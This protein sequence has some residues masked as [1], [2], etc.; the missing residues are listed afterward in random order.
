MIKGIIFDKDGTLFDT[1][2]LNI[3]AWCDAFAYYG[4][5]SSDEHIKKCVGLDKKLADKILYDNYGDK[6]DLI[7]KRKDMTVI[8]EIERNGIPL[9]PGCMEVIDFA[10]ENNLKVAVATSTLISEAVKNLASVGIYNKLN[11]FV[12]GEMVQNGKPAPDIFLLA[13]EK[14]D[15]KPENVIVCEDSRHGIKGA[16]DG[17]FVSV[18]IPDQVSVTDDM[19]DNANYICDSLFDVIELIKELNK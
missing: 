5:S 11:V 10:I 9:K 2:T 16:C 15:L 19:K 12:S 17:G 3:S 7:R 1:E 4:F 13:A 8:D 14:L 6:I 18:L